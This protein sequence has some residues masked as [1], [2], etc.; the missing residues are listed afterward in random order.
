MGLFGGSVA[1]KTVILP[2]GTPSWTP[3]AGVT[4]IAVLVGKGQ[5]GTPAED[6]YVWRYQQQRYQYYRVRHN[7]DIFTMDAGRYSYFDFMPAD[8]CDPPTPTPNDPTFSETWLCYFHSD[9]GY[10]ETSAPTNGSATTGFGKTFPGGAGGPAVEQ[11]FNDVPVTPG[12]AYPLSIPA[13][14]YIKISYYE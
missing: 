1:L 10:W 13:T 7:G 11:G 4:Q 8:Y 9:T 3:P 12:Q 6:Y 2:P 5:N 14:G